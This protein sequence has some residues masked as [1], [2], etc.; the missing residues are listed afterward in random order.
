MAP[1]DSGTVPRRVAEPNL[2]PGCMIAASLTQ[3]TQ[4]RC[5][6]F[7]VH[8]ARSG[9][10]RIERD[11]SALPGIGPQQLIWPP[12]HR[13]RKRADV[14]LSPGPSGAPFETFIPAYWKVS[15]YRLIQLV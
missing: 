11:E 4:Q 2:L 7:A 15:T 6:G 9:L 10:A 5:N 1:T 12:D 13:Q 14:R 3:R 8:G